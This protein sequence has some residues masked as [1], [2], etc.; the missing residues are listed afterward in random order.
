MKNAAAKT[1]SEIRY[2]LTADTRELDWKSQHALLDLGQRWASQNDDLFLARM[3]D[4]HEPFELAPYEELSQWP[5][6]IKA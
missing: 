2:D 1:V 4:N 5:C 6:L 3:Q